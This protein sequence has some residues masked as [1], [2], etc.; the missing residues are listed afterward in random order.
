VNGDDGLAADQPL[1]L[2]PHGAGLW[3]GHS[4]GGGGRRR[5]FFGLSRDGAAPLAG[6]AAAAAEA[7]S[8][9]VRGV[10]LVRGVGGI[11]LGPEVAMRGLS[12]ILT[13]PRASAV[14]SRLHV[15]AG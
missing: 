1:S 3:S 7:D 11:V 15:I 2:L 9:R 8:A 14:V 13:P 12:D 4:G 6:A 10:G 5:L